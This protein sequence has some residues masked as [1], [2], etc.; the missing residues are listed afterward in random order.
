MVPTSV[1]A[2]L[3][4]SHDDQEAKALLLGAHSPGRVRSAIS[5]GPLEHRS[6]RADRSMGSGDRQYDVDFVPGGRSSLKH[7]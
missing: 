3:C 2:A 4:S 5:T 1:E 6:N 7:S